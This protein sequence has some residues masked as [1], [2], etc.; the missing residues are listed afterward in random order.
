MKQASEK[1]TNYRF[2]GIDFP[3][4]LHNDI[5][6]RYSISNKEMVTTQAIVFARFK[7]QIPK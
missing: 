7:N 2:K 6:R 4:A 5:F 1:I 3:V